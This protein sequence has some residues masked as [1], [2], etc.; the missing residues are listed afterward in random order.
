MFFQYVW[1][2]FEK[3][4]NVFGKLNDLLRGR[5]NSIK[6][7]RF[8]LKW[9]LFSSN[10]SKGTFAWRWLENKTYST[11]S[12]Q[13]VTHKKVAIL[14][15]RLPDIQRDKLYKKGKKPSSWITQLWTVTLNP[16]VTKQRW[17]LQKTSSHMWA[18]LMLQNKC[19]FAR[20]SYATN[21]F[22][23]TKRKAC[24][25]NNTAYIRYG[26]Y[27]KKDTIPL[28]AHWCTHFSARRRRHISK[29]HFCQGGYV[30]EDA[31]THFEDRLNED[32]FPPEDELPHEDK[33]RRHIKRRRISP[34]R[35]I[36]PRR[37]I[38]KTH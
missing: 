2:L 25:E 12:L 23:F 26:N 17:I 3:T 28:C 37:Q 21:M 27:W 13:K 14:I 16:I 4:I 18:N 33:F 31:K 22:P 8:L 9:Q 24:C 6:E 38:S 34:R 10:Q 1:Q 19:S 35:R 11:S 5:L 30:N 15:R 36:T 7:R 29:T 20:T 32:E